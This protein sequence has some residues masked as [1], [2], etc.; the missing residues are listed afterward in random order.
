MNKSQEIVYHF[1]AAFHGGSVCLHPSDTL[2]GLTFHPEH[3]K[4]KKS[5]LAIKKKFEDRPF[6]GLINSWEK[7]LAFW[8]PLPAR[9]EKALE[10]LTAKSLTIVWKASSKAPSL[11][12]SAQGYIA[13][14]S[15]VWPSGWK[16]E[17]LWMSE[18]LKNLTLPLP[19]TSVNETGEPPCL[20]WQQATAFLVNKHDV[21]IPDLTSLPAFKTQASTVIQLQDDGSF[22][23]L[24]AGEFS[25]LEIK[26]IVESL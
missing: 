12:V 21:H 19:S 17:E 6:V 14:R 13:L 25:E 9:W 7:A 26:T 3:E 8:Q 1:L 11:L 4:A 22:L 16:P 18:V 10:K 20:N 24:R 5:L 2:P 23:M 15:P